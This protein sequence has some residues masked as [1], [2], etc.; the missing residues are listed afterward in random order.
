MKL[1]N[2][3]RLN[4]NNYPDCPKQIADLISDCFNNAAGMRPSFKY[5]FDKLKSIQFEQDDINCE[6]SNQGQDQLAEEM[7]DQ[8]VRNFKDISIPTFLFD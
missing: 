1:K 4:F 5:L 8:D 2:K 3:N 6:Q 7:M